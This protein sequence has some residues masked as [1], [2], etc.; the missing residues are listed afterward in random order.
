MKFNLKNLFGKHDDVSALSLPK[1]KTIYGVKIER[2]PIGHYA[3]TIQILATLPE[4]LISKCYPELNHD[5]VIK[6]LS[7]VDVELLIEIISKMFTVVPEEAIKII[8]ALVD[9]PF[10]TLWNDPNIGLN[11]LKE[12]IKEFWKINDMSDFW[13]D[14]G[15]AVTKSKTVKSA[16]GMIK[17]ADSAEK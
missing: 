3:K 15:R 11:G 10:E 7:T 5:Q 8:A 2:K 9:V 6:K 14:V 13:K 12:I 16:L 4:E 17:S 1:G